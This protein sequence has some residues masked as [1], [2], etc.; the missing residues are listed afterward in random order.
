[1]LLAAY[2]QGMFP[3]AVNRRGEIRWF[4]P[5]PRAVIPLDDRFHVP[6]GLRRAL[7][8]GRFTVTVDQEFETVIRKCSTAHGESWISKAIINAYCELHRRGFA[9]SVETRLEG[10]LVGGLYGV[11]LGGAF[12]GESMFH[13]ATDASK[14]ALVSLVERLR[15]QGFTLLDTQWTTPH[16][17]QFGTHEIPRDDYL[18]RLEAALAKSCRF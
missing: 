8:K 7:R 14:I 11:H 3:M 16:L 1:M 5:D 10:K 4:S 13:D 12:F 2:C 15:E 6:H 18:R 17:M 9:H